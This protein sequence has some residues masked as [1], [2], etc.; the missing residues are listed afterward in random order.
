MEDFIGKK[1][2]EFDKKFPRGVSKPH[3]FNPEME[4][5]CTTEV[6]AFVSE[7]L[8]KFAQNVIY[9]IT[10]LTEKENTMSIGGF[11]NLLCGEIELLTSTSKQEEEKGK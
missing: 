6:K 9:I 8:K 3:P 5:A 4:I 2:K 11:S 10:D 1:L 7:S